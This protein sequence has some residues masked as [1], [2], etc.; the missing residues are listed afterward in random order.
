MK[1]V[2]ITGANRGV[3][4]ELARQ[5]AARG[6]RVFAGCRSPKKAASLEEIAAKHP[7]QMTILPLEVS[8]EESIAQ[9]AALVS[10]ETASLDIVF[11][12]AAVFS[13]RESIKDFSADDAIQMLNVNAVG[14][15]LVVKHFINYIK[16][17]DD[18]KIINI[19]SE[20]GSISKMMEFR[21][22]YY[23]GSKALLNMFTRAL[24]WD[25]ETQG[26]TVIAIHPGWVRTDMGGPNAHIS[27]TQSAGGLLKVTD[28]LTPT[29]NGK[30]YT[31]EGVEYPW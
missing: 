31:W 14:Q 4:L 10:N 25:S 6:D 21:G 15:M 16:A 2:L 18:P 5:C 27:P 17:G 12:N 9:S 11:N 24:A 22:Y 29:D 1:S 28:G 26:I 8:E 13:N 7:E 20:A 30:F 23:Y 3:G 19:S